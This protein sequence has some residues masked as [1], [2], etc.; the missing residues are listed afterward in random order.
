VF[1]I[2]KQ[3][4]GPDEYIRIGDV[5]ISDSGHINILDVSQ[6]TILDYNLK[7][8]LETRKEFKNWIHEYC[9]AD[10]YEYLF[11]ATPNQPKG[12]YVTVLKKS[13]KITSYFPTTHNWHF[14]KTEFLRNGDSVFFTRRYDDCIYY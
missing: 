8:E 13:K 1:C 5:S 7:G 9:C 2:D 4:K 10:G 11:S 14:D 12:N 3:G 6:K